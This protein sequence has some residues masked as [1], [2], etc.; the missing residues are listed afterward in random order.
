MATAVDVMK[1]IKSQVR[2]S[3][4]VQLQKLVY[5]A[6]AWSIAWDGTPLFPE[7][8][9]AWKHGPVVPALYKR[10][11]AADPNALSPQDRATVDAVLAHY[12]QHFGG[13]L[14]AM[15]HQEQPWIDA[16]ARRATPDRGSEEIT[17]DVMRRFYTS[18]A[19]RGEGPRRV[20]DSQ[21]LRADAAEDEVSQ[22]AAA[23]ARRWRETL[24]ILGQ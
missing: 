11:D 2:V 1:Y 22:I 7:R 23:N 14:R 21:V 18:V 3:G 6:Q 16:W 20:P 19:L 12:G 15:S 9:E 5:Y 24:A 17:V 8:I 10:D 4:A 13:S